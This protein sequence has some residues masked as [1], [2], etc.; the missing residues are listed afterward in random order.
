MSLTIEELKDKL[1]QLDEVSLVELLE[2]TAE[3]IIN[4]C[5]DLIEEQY[6]TLESQ[7]DDTIPWDND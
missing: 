3:D 4:R 2:L 6:E 7:F 5:A 1:K